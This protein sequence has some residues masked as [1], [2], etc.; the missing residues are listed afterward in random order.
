MN[1]Q[2]NNAAFMA[3][4]YAASPIFYIE[5]ENSGDDANGIQSRVT[6]T[7]STTGSLCIGGWNEG[8]GSA[9]Y[10]QNKLAD[11]YG[12]LGTFNH[13]AYGENTGSSNRGA[14][15]T[16]TSGAYGVH[17]ASGN[18]GTLGLTN[19]GVQGTNGTTD[20]WAALGGSSYGV[21]ARLTADGSS[22]TLS[23]NDFAVKG[24]GVELSTPTN[25]NRGSNYSNQVG[26]VFGNNVVGTEYSAGVLGFTDDSNGDERTSGVFG[27]IENT[28]E[29]GALGYEHSGG[30]N[31]GGYFTNETTGSGKAAGSA[32][33]SVGIGVYGDLFGAHVSGEVY[34]LYAKG[35]KYGLYSEGDLY[36]TGADVHIQKDNSGKSNVM[37]TL[38]SPEMTI[39]TYGIGELK[40]GKANISF[41]DAFADIVTDNEPIIVT[42]T[43][44][45]ESEGVHLKEVDSKGFTIVENKSG[46]STVQFTWIAIGKRKGYENNSLPADVIADDYDQKIDEGLHNDADMTTDGKGLYYDKGNLV[47]GN[48]KPYKVRTNATVNKDVKLN[49]EANLEKEKM[50]EPEQEYIET[51]DVP[52]R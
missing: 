28:S 12:Y 38:V 9:V 35:E 27:G 21:Y 30:T 4:S 31:Y 26:G 2:G 45:G 50:M 5:V 11:N 14:L 15:G 24:V 20:F 34:G 33:S 49:M 1:Y 40:A 18:Q 19:S 3:F 41:D 37:Y 51:E 22:Q 8:N 42:V 36:R 17:D 48:P 6:S 39:Q 16:S 32:S 47:V 46:K 13:G 44:I 7:S 23:A 52:I 25:R 10:G 43:P 29:W